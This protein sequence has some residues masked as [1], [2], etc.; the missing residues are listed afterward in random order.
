M[1][2][3]TTPAPKGSTCRYIGTAVARA[4]VQGD[5]HRAR[6]LAATNPW[7]TG[8]LVPELRAITGA[9]AFAERAYGAP[10]GLANSVLGLRIPCWAGD[11]VCT[12]GR[13]DPH[14][15]ARR[16]TA[17]GFT[18]CAWSDGPV[19]A[20]LGRKIDG[21]PIVRPRTPEA[22]E[23]ARSAAALLLGEACLWD[24]PDMAR[25]YS[26][27]RAVAK[28]SGQPAEVGEAMRVPSRPHA[29]VENNGR[30]P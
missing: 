15:I 5:V 1:K 10:A 28:R 25:L 8:W 7:G 4:I 21:L 27:C 12:C 30:G 11:A 13:T 9:A 23:L 16:R 18:V 24:L 3:Q 22:I 19:T 29:R 2:T 6:L 14:V 20:E 26:V 17:D